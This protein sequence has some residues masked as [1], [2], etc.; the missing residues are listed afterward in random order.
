MYIPLRGC[1]TDS[2]GCADIATARQIYRT[3]ALLFGIAAL[4]IVVVNLFLH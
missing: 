3:L 4:V 2:P 1:C